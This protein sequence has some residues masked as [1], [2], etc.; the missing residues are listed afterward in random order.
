MDMPESSPKSIETPWARSPEDVLSDLD[1][2][3]ADGLQDHAAEA[4][5]GRYGPNRL[6]K[7]QSRAAGAIL[8]DQ[9]KNLIIL[10][11]SLAAVAS[12][13]FDQYLEAAAILVAIVLNVAIGFFTEWRATR[14]MEAL[15]H[16]GRVDARVRRG[17]RIRAIPSEELVPGDIVLL[18]GGDMVAA[19]LRILQASRLAMDESALT[20]ESVPV[21]KQVDPVDADAATADQR[22]MLFKGTAVTRG[23]AEG[24]VVAVGM[25][26]ELGRIAS[27]AE[28]S[29]GEE[30]PLEKRLDRLGYRL[31]WL[32]LAIA[33]L[34][35]VAGVLARKDLLLMI[36][37]AIALAVAAA[38]E[39]LP[40][41]ATI[42]LA[43]GMWR[44]LK[45]N[46]LMNRL[47]AVETLGST[48]VIFTDKT[49]TLTENRMTVTR[50][51]LAGDTP[52]STTT[53]RVDPDAGDV[54][55]NNGNAVAPSENGTLQAA[56]ETGVLCNNADLD[57][58]AGDH[59]DNGVGDPL[60]IALLHAGRL[61]GMQRDDLLTARPEVRE[62]AF[63]RDVK[64]M[65]T[66]HEEAAGWRVAVKGAPEAVIAASHRLGQPDNGREFGPEERRHWHDLSADLAAEGLRVLA[67]AAKRADHKEAAPYEN[68]NFL[69]LI[70]MADPPRREVPE[71]VAA[72]GRAGIDVVMV[73]GDHPATAGKVAA[74][75]GIAA[76]DVPQVIAGKD[77]KGPQELSEEERRTYLQNRVFARVSPEQKLNLI[78]LHQADGAVVAMTGDGVNDAPALKK[79]D[80]GIAMGR[81]GTQVAREAAD[82]VL[83]DDAFG[84]IVAAVAQGRS[85]F[86]NIRKF[87]FF[88]LSGNV[89]EILI[90]GIAILAGSPLPLLPLQILYLNMIGDVFPALALAAGD[91]DAA[92]MREPPRDAGEAILTRDHWMGIGAYGAVIAATVLAAF[93]LA[94][95]TLALP[96]ERAVTVSFLSLSFARLWHVFNMRSAA[97][98]WI[99]NEITR[100][101]YVWGALALC[102]ALLLMAVYLPGLSQVLKL[103]G[104]DPVEWSLILGLSLFPLAVGQ[105]ALTVLSGRKS[106]AAKH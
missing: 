92:R 5:H 53:I 63:D 70:A 15:Q 56:L 2:S 101:P 23:S 21:D 10:L 31:I 41:V 71:A 88:L 54:F 98:P 7:A 11:L 38:P 86:E 30:T 12:F 33:A 64:M 50:I 19:D 32:T 96:L 17:G 16:L 106:A 82:M 79:A 28:A 9:L 20:G 42:G 37:T 26:T 46:A 73:T 25:D 48:S 58:D 102:T 81:R 62:E 84:T 68:L 99:D 67:V 22:S 55:R 52:N 89:G 104:P 105:T 77:L 1:V 8:L 14:S 93:W 51:L 13:I 80:I 57:H 66:F 76:Q 72:C 83:Q 97:S 74:L 4:R 91:G 75:T 103:V 40:M 3:S 78:R 39:G 87:I 69:G 94:L 47:S 61:A 85:I 44:M 36:E 35:T 6:K 65:A 59:D 18:E 60:E 43:R 90:V 24:V 100:N 45:R 29:G 34:V 95:H 49:G 27:L